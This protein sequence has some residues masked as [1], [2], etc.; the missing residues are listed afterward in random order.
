MQRTVQQVF[1]RGFEGLWYTPSTTPGTLSSWLVD[2]W[3]LHSHLTWD[4]SSECGFLLKYL[5]PTQDGYTSCGVFAL[6][7]VSPSH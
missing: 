2:S 1:I 5:P 7:N 6:G 3:G 4:N